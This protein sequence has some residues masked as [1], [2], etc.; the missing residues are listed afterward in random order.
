VWRGAT[1]RTESTANRAKTPCAPRKHAREQGRADAPR[2]SRAHAGA[3]LHTRRATRREQAA[4]PR[5]GRTH[6]VSSGAAP[7]A[8]RAIAMG[9]PRRHAKAT[10]WASRGRAAAHGGRHARAGRGLDRGA[11]P[12]RARRAEGEP[13]RGG[14]RQGRGSG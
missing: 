6:C 2:T 4:G 5:Q 14:P 9:A 12:S 1:R 10:S 7:G 13:G 11:I 3:E 8:D